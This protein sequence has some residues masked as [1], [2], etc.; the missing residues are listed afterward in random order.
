MASCFCREKQPGPS[1][2]DAVIPMEAEI[3]PMNPLES[4]DDEDF[5]NVEVGEVEEEKYDRQICFK[6]C[7][8]FYIFVFSCYWQPLF[9]RTLV[10]GHVRPASAA[11]EAV[12]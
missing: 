1:T 10:L 3:V 7:S 6:C 8:R 2:D 4:S 12:S 5:E 11:F 9:M